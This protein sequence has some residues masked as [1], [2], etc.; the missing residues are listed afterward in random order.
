MSKIIKSKIPFLAIFFCFLGLNSC[1]TRKPLLEKIGETSEID[2]LK[3]A[4]VAYIFKDIA[5]DKII[6]EK[7]ADKLYTPAS[8]IKLLTL[9]SVLKVYPDSLPSGWTYETKDSLI[10][11]PSG[12]PSFLY[13]DFNDD[14]LTNR[15]KNSSKL[16]QPL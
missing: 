10:F 9:Y 2:V 14:K 12:D 5:T 8:N 11:I 4:H 3:N 6:A 13:K 1:I 7:D 15:L 16:V